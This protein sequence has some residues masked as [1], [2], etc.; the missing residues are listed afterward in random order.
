MSEQAFALWGMDDVA[1]IKR[2]NVNGE[3]AWVI[4]AA[5][6]TTLWATPDRDVAFAICSQHDRVGCSVH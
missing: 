2:V 6:G 4:F 1:Y 3:L 5:D